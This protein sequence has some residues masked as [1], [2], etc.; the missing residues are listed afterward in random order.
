MVRCWTAILS[1]KLEDLSPAHPDLWRIC[2]VFGPGEWC[3]RRTWVREVFDQGGCCANSEML[4][5]FPVQMQ[6]AQSRQLFLNRSRE[7]GEFRA[8]SLFQLVDSFCESSTNVLPC[9]G[10]R[11]ILHIQQPRLGPRPEEPTHS[12]VQYLS[13]PTTT[14]W[15][16]PE[17]QRKSDETRW[18]GWST[19]DPQLWCTSGWLLLVPAQKQQDKCS[20]RV[21]CSSEFVV[22]PVCVVS[23]F[24][25]S[26][27]SPPLL[28]PPQWVGFQLSCSMRTA[29]W[30]LLLTSI[31]SKDVLVWIWGKIV[32]T[33]SFGAHLTFRF[34]TATSSAREGWCTFSFCGWICLFRCQNLRTQ[35]SQIPS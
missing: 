4:P 16:Q 22:I 14:S 8:L 25:S 29:S 17:L 19:P 21:F 6:Q 24:P 2:W 18:S 23:S 27:P 11:W 13:I 31:F 15:F 35:S 28:F 26:S 10:R 12:R 33:I 30:M 9:L 7:Y 3:Q 32:Q 1:R 5:R 34:V 20:S